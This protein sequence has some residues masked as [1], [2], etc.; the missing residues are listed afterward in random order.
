MFKIVLILQA[1]DS[2]PHGPS[3]QRFEDRLHRSSKT[4]PQVYVVGQS[5]NK[6]SAEVVT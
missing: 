1:L 4:P 3:A 2:L 5:K 6:M